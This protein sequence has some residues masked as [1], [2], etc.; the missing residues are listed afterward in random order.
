MQVT[1]TQVIRNFIQ[2]HGRAFTSLDV[3]R[4]T[5][6]KRCTAANA[7]RD[8]RLKGV[9]KVIG[10][11]KKQLIYIKTRPAPLAKKQLICPKV[12]VVYP[13]KIDVA[14]GIEEYIKNV[15]KPFTV[16]DA[17]AHTGCKLFQARNHLA[18]LK[19][20]KKIT[21]IAFD[22]LTKIYV[23]GD[24]KITPL[25]T[26]VRLWETIKQHPKRTQNQLIK[27]TGLKNHAAN[28]WLRIFRLE[29]VVNYRF[30]YGNIIIYENAVPELPIFK[31]VR[32][33]Q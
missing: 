25:T 13:S 29:K 5:G 18:L 31:P 6:I 30:T 26:P 8:F 22:G 21:L 7:L 19:W 32:Q 24:Q 23:Y 12:K 11:E 27:L 2:F 28:T 15:D 20:Q 9:I 10:T 3:E 4:V 17:A 16:R 14:Q 33:Y 1:K